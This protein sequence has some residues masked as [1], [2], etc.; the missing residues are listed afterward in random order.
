[1]TLLDKMKSW[2]GGKSG[3]CI[4]AEDIAF[5]LAVVDSLPGKYAFLKQQTARPELW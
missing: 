1:M 3:H 5:L 4:P 2:F